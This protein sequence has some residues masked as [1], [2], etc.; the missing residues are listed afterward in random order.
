MWDMP[1]FKH[2]KRQ[3]AY[4]NNNK[5][6]F[7]APFCES[8]QGSFTL[9]I[10]EIILKKIANTYM[11]VSSTYTNYFT[12]YDLVNKNVFSFDLK[13][14]N[15]S[16]WRISAGRLFQVAGPAALKARLPYVAVRVLGTNRSPRFADL[17]LDRWELSP[18]GMHSSRRYAGPSPRR[19]L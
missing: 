13:T 6:C 8:P 7:L 19:A 3:Y 15:V 17:W 4:N 1:T 9:S 2:V 10:I 11:R 5:S 14:V 12:G 16:D 18:T